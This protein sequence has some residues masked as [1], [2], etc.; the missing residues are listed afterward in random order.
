[1]SKFGLKQ[2]MSIAVASLSLA[3]SASAATAYINQVG[4]RTTD[5]KEFTLFEGSGDIEIVDAAGKTVLTVT[6]KAASKWNPSGQSVQ[7]VDFSE[8]KTPGTYS[9]KQGGQVLRSDLKIA[10]KVF[11]D[12][13]M[14]AIRMRLFRFIILRAVRE[15][16]NRAKAG[17][18]RATMAATL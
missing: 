7:L 9:I 3:S 11:E 2:Y 6:P 12:V 1:M 10:D 5:P 13:A 4:Y 17:T 16:S 14:R 8:L 18:M 15:Q